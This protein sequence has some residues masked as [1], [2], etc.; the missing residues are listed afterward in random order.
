M[1]GGEEGHGND[2]QIDLWQVAQNLTSG[3]PSN[4]KCSLQLSESLLGS[5]QLTP[6]IQLHNNFRGQKALSKT[7][8]FQ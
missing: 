8:A 4:V 3:V 1:G 5:M 2:K 6:A 7:W